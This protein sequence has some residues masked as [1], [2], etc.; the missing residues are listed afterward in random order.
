MSL[1]T[2]LLSSPPPPFLMQVLAVDLVPSASIVPL[3]HS[4]CSSLPRQIHDVSVD[5]RHTV[6]RGPRAR[7]P[8]KRD[9]Y[10]CGDYCRKAVPLDCCEFESKGFSLF[11]HIILQA[12]TLTRID[13]YTCQLAYRVPLSGLGGIGEHQTLCTINILQIHIKNCNYNGIFHAHV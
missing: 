6:R 12:P 8:R 5:K 13:L 3:S 1:P 10:L 9:T 4:N 7:G 11:Y 2:P